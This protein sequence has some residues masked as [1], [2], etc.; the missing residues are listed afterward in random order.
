MM[1]VLILLGKFKTWV[2]VI[3]Y[4]VSFGGFLALTSYMPVFENTFYGLNIK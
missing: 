3:N 1:Q 4:F 2:L